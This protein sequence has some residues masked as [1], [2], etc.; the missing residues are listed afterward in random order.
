MT[1]VNFPLPE[2]THTVILGV[3]DL[4]GLMRGK[5]IPADQW[6][7]I[8]GSG[9]ALAMSLFTMDMTCDVWETPIVGFANG[10][11]DCHIFPMHPPVA[12]PWEPGVAMCFARAEGM[13]HG[14]LTVDPRQALLRQVE[15]A[16]QVN[17][18]AVGH[19]ARVGGRNLAARNREIDA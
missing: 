19:Q 15:R 4:N 5:R 17:G 3:G 10:F 7:R 13:D 6:P 14:A 11:P 2:G 1:E 12:V 16:D 8:C 18:A 9:N